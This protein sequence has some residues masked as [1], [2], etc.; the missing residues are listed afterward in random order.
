M[1][2]KIVIVQD[3]ALLAQALQLVV[4]EAGYEVVG[5]T[6]DT[7]GADRLVAKHRPVL[8]I[9]DMMLEL[10]VDGI[11]TATAL[12]HKHGIK[13]LITTGFPDSLMEREGARDLACA[14]V[15]KPYM[16]E[17]VVQAVAHCLN[18]GGAQPP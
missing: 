7:A 15:R 14:I 18:A 12:K 9:V 13:I 10:D 11:A 6:R 16:D 2:Q 17:E 1:R 3:D 5:V 8:A 4:E